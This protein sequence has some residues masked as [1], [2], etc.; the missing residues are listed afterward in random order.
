MLPMP[1]SDPFFAY[2]ATELLVKWTNQSSRL[3]ASY[4]TAGNQ[5]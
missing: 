1:I 5:M 3:F 4:S 2:F